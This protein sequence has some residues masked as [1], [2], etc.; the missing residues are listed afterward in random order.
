MPMTDTRADALTALQRVLDTVVLSQATRL[1][2]DGRLADAEQLLA[3]RA[4]A[5]DAPAVVL[6]LLA[7]VYAQ[8]GRLAEA[9]KLWTRALQA[10]PGNPAMAAAL[11]K[12]TA[13]KGHAPWVPAVRVVVPTFLVLIAVAGAAAVLSYR[14]SVQQSDTDER[15]AAIAGQTETLTADIQRLSDTL[16]SAE[17]ARG[18]QADLLKGWIESLR[19]DSTSG[20][21]PTCQYRVKDGDTLRSVA[22]DYGADPW[23]VARA[24]LIYDL[25]HIFTGQ[26]LV[27]PGC[28]RLP[29]Q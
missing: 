4:H 27:I 9:R 17:I 2:R 10:D 25:N 18:L 7:K 22:A 12:A 3:G 20:E 1:A 6:D 5:P 26:L 13:A 15:L 21:S 28:D 19:A 23:T 11:A 14:M 29:S 8:Q 16:E 24:N